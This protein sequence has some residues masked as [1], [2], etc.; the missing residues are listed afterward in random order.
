MKNLKTEISRITNPFS[1][2]FIYKKRDERDREERRESIEIKIKILIE[3][4]HNF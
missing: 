1:S 3:N 2:V 4:G